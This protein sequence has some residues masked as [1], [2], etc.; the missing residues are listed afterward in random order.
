MINRGIALVGAGGHAVSILNAVGHDCILGYV[1]PEPND[2]LGLQWLA[3]DEEFL[4]SERWRD[5]PVNISLVAG[6]S[7]N[8]ALRRRIAELYVN[9]ARAT[10]VAPTAIITAGTELGDGCSVMSGAI[11][12]GA[13]LGRDCIVNTGA[14]VEHACMI[15]DNV[16]IGPNATVCGGVSVGCD[17]FIGAGATLLNGIEICSGA[18]IGGGAVVVSDITEP[19]VYAGVPAKILHK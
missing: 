1:A 12:N 6:R 4:A 14:V 2:A 11:V 8:M 3:T 18:V 15:S 13:R 16:F 9:H 17:C 10:I 7:G 5:I 19:G